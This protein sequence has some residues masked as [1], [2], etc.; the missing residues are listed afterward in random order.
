MV[1]PW[2]PCFPRGRYPGGTAAAVRGGLLIALRPDVF[3]AEEVGDVLGIVTGKAMALHV[4][5]AG[6]MLTVINIHGAGSGGDSRASKASFLTDV[7]MYAATMRVGATR[8][9][10]I[11]GELQRVA[12]VPRAPQGGSRP[13]GISVRS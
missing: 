8:P 10:L 5:T 3:T 4:V 1:S 11:R 7:A 13:R 6:G 2:I 9:V 12:R